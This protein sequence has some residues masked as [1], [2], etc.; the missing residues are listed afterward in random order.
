M[1]V[2][3]KQDVART[4]RRTAPSGSEPAK[5]VI[6]GGGAAGLAAAERLR[7]EGFDGSLIIL[8]ND[9]SP[10]VDRP[11]LSKDYLAGHAPEDWV[12]LRPDNFYSDNA[13]DLQLRKEVAAVDTRS[14]EITLSNGDCIGYDR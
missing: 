9:A 10:P 7:R 13:I 12:Y 3:G 2:K 8:S 6:V 5:I 1:F 11:N 4:S 14:R